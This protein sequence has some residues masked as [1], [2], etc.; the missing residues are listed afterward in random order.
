ME[1]RLPFD[2]TTPEGRHNYLATRARQLQSCGYKVLKIMN[3]DRDNDG[4]A[5][6]VVEHKDGGRFCAVYLSPGI[7]G[8]GALKETV[9]WMELPVITI[10]DCEIA[11]YL[12][13]NNI[14]H[15][16]EKG[17]F[18]TLEY[19]LIEGYYA[20]RKAKRSDVWLMNHIDEGL[21][22]LNQIGQAMTP[23]L[24]FACTH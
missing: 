16:V 20:N 3:Q 5:I 23:R 10:R 21:T 8:R 9:Q 7:R 13:F 2:A 6:M 4:L 11:G 1:S 14:E 19:A 12:Q 15:I 18:D 24:F 17:Y 22:V